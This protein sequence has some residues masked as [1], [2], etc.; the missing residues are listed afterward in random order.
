MQPDE[1]AR[2][3]EIKAYR[4]KKYRDRLVA[5]SA[6]YRAKNKANPKPCSNCTQVKTIYHQ[7]R[8]ECGACYQHQRRH[9]EP[10]PIG[11]ASG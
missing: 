11:Q 3:R 2:E 6:R 10:R 4:R 1:R 9:G 5:Q 8:Q 7:G